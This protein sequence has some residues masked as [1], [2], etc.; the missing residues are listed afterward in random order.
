MEYLFYWHFFVVSN[1]EGENIF[2]SFRFSV[3]HIP[4]F[5]LIVGYPIYWLEL[6]VLRTPFGRTSWLAWAIFGFISVLI[7]VL[8]LAGWRKFFVESKTWWEAQGILQK[9]FVVFV[10]L[11][12]L[13][14]LLIGAAAALLP[15]HLIQESDSLNYHITIPRQHLI[16]GSFAHLPWSV[17]DFYSLPLDFAMAP[18]CLSTPW[19]NKLAFYFFIIG[20]LGL[21]WQLAWRISKKNVWAC[22]AVIMAILGAH[23]LSIQIGIAMFDVLLLYLFLAA[24]DSAMTG[25]WFLAVVEFTFYFWSKSFIPIQVCVLGVALG[26]IFLIA[27]R[28][29]W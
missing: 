16:L 8:R 21:S 2:R 1:M 20:I 3:S 18:Y 7:L 28:I 4:T 24:V 26:I 10:C 15:P 17:A 23:G 12:L 9:G 29:K 11:L 22:I 25:N 27:K 19:P 5:F 14:M 6:Y 13:G